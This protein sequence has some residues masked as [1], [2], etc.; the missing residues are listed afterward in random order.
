[1]SCYDR[2]RS[3]RCVEL[4]GGGG[5]PMMSN[6]LTTTELRRSLYV[7]ST[8]ASET[9]GVWYELRIDLIS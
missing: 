6:I 1:M 7:T 4:A 9:G 2:Q 5:L 3:P 8:I